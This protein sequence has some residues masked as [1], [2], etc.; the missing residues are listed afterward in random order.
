MV[1]HFRKFLKSS[2]WFLLK[3][4]LYSFLTFFIRLVNAFNS[5]IGSPANGYGRVGTMGKSRLANEV[6]FSYHFYI[7]FLLYYFRICNVFG[8][9]LVP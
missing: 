9:M 4:N 2:E 7:K 8:H 6:K 3:T 5:E 1:I